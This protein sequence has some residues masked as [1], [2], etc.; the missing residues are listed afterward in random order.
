MPLCGESSTSG[1]LP[2]M[3]VTMGWAPWQAP[4]AESVRGPVPVPVPAPGA[5]FKKRGVGGVVVIGKR[6]HWGSGQKGSRAGSAGRVLQADPLVKN[7]PAAKK[8]CQKSPGGCGQGLQR[9]RGKGSGWRRAEART[10]LNLWK[11]LCLALLGRDSARAQG[12]P[13]PA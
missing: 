2:A 8:A 9:H 1:V 13:P 10:A 7:P 3:L 5:A 6:L 12:T 4:A 11:A